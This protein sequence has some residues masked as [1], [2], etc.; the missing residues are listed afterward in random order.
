MIFEKFVEISNSLLREASGLDGYHYD[1]EES[2]GRR[3]YNAPRFSHLDNMHTFAF[4]EIRS[5]EAF[6]KAVEINFQYSASVDRSNI[7]SNYYVA[8]FIDDKDKSSYKETLRRITKIAK[9]MRGQKINESNLFYEQKQK[10]MLSVKP[11]SKKWRKG[12]LLTPKNIEHSKGRTTRLKRG[13]EVMIHHFDADRFVGAIDVD[14]P[15]TYFFLARYS[16]SG[17][18]DYYEEEIGTTTAGVAGTGDDPVVGV[19]V[20]RKKKRGSYWL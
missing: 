14:D 17:G 5:A 2:R 20:P 12:V 7:K 19:R 13:D 1:D 11:D 4:R 10:G 18:L 3:S 9:D 16:V 6:A 15:M 8:V